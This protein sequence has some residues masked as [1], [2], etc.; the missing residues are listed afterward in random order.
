[1]LAVF[2]KEIAEGLIEQGYMLLGKSG[3][4]WFFKD[5]EP[6]RAFL[7]EKLTSGLRK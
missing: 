7:E 6:A 1:M 5:T 2:T 4:A 3:K